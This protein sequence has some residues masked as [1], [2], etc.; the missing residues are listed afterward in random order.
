[1]S[2]ELDV[3]HLLLIW[4][5]DDYGETEPSLILAA[6]SR[7]KLELKFSNYLT[8]HREEEDYMED[9]E[10]EGFTRNIDKLIEDAGPELNC[11]YVMTLTTSAPGY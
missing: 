6:S 4:T 9:E 3:Y 8:Q 11:A 1:M 5:R 10:F 7:E 2:E